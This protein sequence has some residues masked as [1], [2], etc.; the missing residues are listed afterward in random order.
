MRVT[1]SA[2]RRAKSVGDD[3]PSDGDLTSAG[4]S[5]ASP[6]TG[7]DDVKR[8]TSSKPEDEEESKSNNLDEVEE[9]DAADSDGYTRFRAR[10]SSLLAPKRRNLRGE[11]A[12]IV[13]KPSPLHRKVLET[14]AVC[15]Q[16]ETRSVRSP[17]F[18]QFF[19]LVL[20]Q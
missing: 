19:I 7:C 15:V 11:W 5:S 16:Q 4:P 17:F 2:A 6:S 9:E 10:L 14:C 12:A 1:R 8:P 18:D 13:G 3:K 20:G